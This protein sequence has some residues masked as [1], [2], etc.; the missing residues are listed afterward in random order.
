MDKVIWPQYLEFGY[1]SRGHKLISETD[2]QVPIELVSLT[3]IPPS[4]PSNWEYILNCSPIDTYFAIWYTTP[5]LTQKRAG[6]VK[7]K[8]AIWPIT[9]IFE[10]EEIDTVL[11]KLLGKNVISFSLPDDERLT[12]LNSLIDSN[13][14]CLTNNLEQWPNIISFL[15]KSLWPK[16]RKNLSLH[17]VFKEQ[18]T[19][20]LLNPTLYC[21]LGNYELSWTDKFHKIKNHDKQN[22]KNISE[23]LLDKESEGFIYFKDLI[24]DYSNLNELRIVD[25]I[26]NIYQEYK[27][28]PNISNS[29]KLL[30]AS[31]S[32]E[33]DKNPLILKLVKETTDFINANINNL[34]CDQLF[35]LANIPL[36][37]EYNIDIY[38][39]MIS[40]IKNDFNIKK[41]ENILKTANEKKSYK[42]WSEIVLA[43]FSYN[44]NKT[45][46]LLAEYLSLLSNPVISQIIENILIDNES[47]ETKLCDETKFSAENI[48]KNFLDFCKKNNWHHAHSLAVG[49]FY[50]AKE[51]LTHQLTFNNPQSLQSLV[52]NYPNSKIIYAIIEYKDTSILKFVSNRILLDK[53]ILNHIDL[54]DYIWLKVWLNCLNIDNRIIPTKETKEHYIHYILNKII[55]NDNPEKIFN[56]IIQIMHIDDEISNIFL[57]YE[58]RPLIWSH[59]G[60]PQK[61]LIVNSVA[62]KLLTLLAVKNI[63]QPEPFLSQKIIQLAQQKNSLPLNTI[64]QLIQWHSINEEIAKY[65]LSH[66]SWQSQSNRIGIIIRQKRWKSIAKDI[67]SSYKNGNKQFKE[68]IPHIKTLLSRPERLRLKLLE[69]RSFPTRNTIVSSSEINEIII[70]LCA[71]LFADRLQTIW[72][73][74]GGKASDL[75]NNGTIYDQW[76]HA[77]NTA[78]QGKINKYPKSI[79]DILA[80][81]FPRNE[82]VSNLIQLLG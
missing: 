81:E 50:D 48:T 36:P 21:V 13:S 34:D 29:I 54:G 10:Q 44:I 37:P 14:V 61:N 5:D 51:S 68:I 57:N 46:E 63:S 22:R 45:N 74:A 20:S 41:I 58:N 38:N 55:S 53:K 60:N 12:I 15:W 75:V 11:N 76:V 56:K 4:Q 52:D 35:S 69:A 18:D 9:H 2:I 31:L 67:Y 66:G 79:V 7:S 72:L 27:K 32:T 80:H 49:Y 23:F 16:S 71:E 78:S 82:D 40:N 43:G 28:N 8:V 17:C 70:E 62:E 73:R 30:R 33:K 65:L 24:Y 25:R 39:W 26:I 77:I 3:D 59:I 64:I 47:F 42:W 6:S 19:T 1:T